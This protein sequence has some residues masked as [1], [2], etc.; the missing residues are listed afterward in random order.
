MADELSKEVRNEESV[1]GGQVDSRGGCSDGIADAGRTVIEKVSKLCD[2]LRASQEKRRE[3][4]EARYPRVFGSGTH[5]PDQSIGTVYWEFGYGWDTLIE[6][7]AAAIDREIEMDPSLAVDDPENGKFAFK[8][9]QMKEKFGTLR[10]YYSGGND[11]I[12]GLVDMTEQLS[13]SVC[14]VCGSLGTLCKKN[15]GSW[16]RTLCEDCAQKMG[17]TPMDFEEETSDTP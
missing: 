3:E 14:E 9:Q 17:Y 10:F 15:N 12:H 4:I 13:G 8:V 5:S 16:I 6:N 7:L 1:Q 11:R 2:D